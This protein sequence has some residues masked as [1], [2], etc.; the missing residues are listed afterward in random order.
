MEYAILFNKLLMLPFEEAIELFEDYHKNVGF[1]TFAEQQKVLDIMTHKKNI[2]DRLKDDVIRDAAIA[3]T[4]MSLG[5]N[6][7][8]DC[9]FNRMKSYPMIV[10]IEAI[11]FLKDEEIFELLRNYHSE[12]PTSLIAVYMANMNEELQVKAIDEFYK[13]LDVEDAMISNLYFAISEKARNKLK[14]YYPDDF[15]SDILFEAED[16]KE[17]EAL[18][19]LIRNKETVLELDADDFLEFILLKVSNGS[20]LEKVNEHFKELIESSSDEKFELFFTRYKYLAWYNYQDKSCDY[21]DDDDDYDYDYNTK[22]PL[23]DNDLFH[24]FIKKFHK[25]GVER[26]LLL[27]DRKNY[28]GKNEFTIEVVLNLLDVAYGDCDISNYANDATIKELIE[29]F[30]LQCRE[31][32]YTLSDFERLVK[33]IEYN[34]RTKLIFDDY[35][36]AIVACGKLLKGKVIDDKNP[37]FIE[38]RD[39]FNHDLISRSERDGSYDEDVSFNGIFYRLAKGSMSFEDVYMT[40]TYKGLIY[41]TK[42]GQL[43]ANADYITNFLT[44]KQ[45]V[46]LNISPM[47]KWKRTINRTNTNADNLSFVE[48]MGL[49]LLCYFGRDKGKYLLES[50]MQGNFMEN[51][52]DGLNYSDISINEDGSANVNSE[53][54][55]FLFGYGRTTEPNSIMNKLI[56]GELP[57]FKRH[58]TEFCNE[59]FNIK[60]ACNGA[61]SV[62]RIVN[63]FSDSNLPIELV[64]DEELF[65]NALIEMNTISEGKLREAIS[66]CKDARS[67]DYSTI[68]KVSGKIGDFRYEVLDLDDPLAVAVGELS[69]CCFVV[70]GISYS[71]LKHSMQS[72]NG[73]T[74][75]VYYQGNFLTQ[76]WIWRNGDVICFDSVEAGSPVHGAYKDEIKLVDVYQ[77][78]ARKMLRMSRSTEDD[79]QRVKVVT[80]GKSDYTFNDLERFE[81]DVPRP[82]EKNIYVYDSSSQNILAGSVSSKMRYGEVGA[83]YYDERK[84]PIIF[85]DVSKTN[86]DKLDEASLNINAL[87]YRVHG[88]EEPIDFSNYLRIYSGDG[89]YILEDLE[90]NIENGKVKTD[91]DTVAEFDKYMRIIT[92]REKRKSVKTY[93]RG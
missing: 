83:R 59:Y 89:W 20:N 75:V 37:L 57:E 45:L 68:P 82:L 8:A 53:L 7:A 22:K 38:L 44:D 92:E 93:G 67:R 74:F 13:N 63:Y 81:G 55:N 72:V 84:K 50:N 11:I 2:V 71:S 15:G 17:D 76:G 35:I 30:S 41:L 65:R 32:E 9:A 66:L 51:L 69:H 19:F 56:R 58:F 34:G 91:E 90:G 6:H 61:L 26:T 86:I 88:V 31:K 40:K 62:K 46:K 23:T 36:E 64:P 79:I 42:C 27:F 77:E 25:L 4:F 43:T 12:L 48:R 18:E 3:Y 73:R 54:I 21:D 29:K 16:L 78:A 87:R 28:Y 49:Q 39:K 33:K 80:V 85:E 1:K 5:K 60:E 14:E 52:F 10:W 47:I 24:M 70:R